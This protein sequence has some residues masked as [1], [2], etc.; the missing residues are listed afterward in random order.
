MKSIRLGTLVVV[1][2]GQAGVFV[3]KLAEREGDRVVLRDSLRLGSWRVAQTTGH[4]ASGGDPVVFMTLLDSQKLQ[5]ELAPSATRIEQY[6][7]AMK[8]EITQQL[9]EVVAGADA[10]EQAVDEADAR[11]R[12]RHEAPGL[13]EDGDQRVLAQEGRFARHVGAGHEP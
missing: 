9:L 8:A 6:W 12:R 11:A 1:R 3:G 4:V 5:F 2:S 10:A 13:G 7:A